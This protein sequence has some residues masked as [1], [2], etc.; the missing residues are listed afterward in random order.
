MSATRCTICRRNYPLQGAICHPCKSGESYNQDQDQGLKG[1]DETGVFPSEMQFPGP[2][3]NA[4]APT[5]APALVVNDGGDDGPDMYRLEEAHRLGQLDPVPVALGAMPPFAGRV[6]RRV[7]EHMQLRMGLRRAD[8]EDRP[9]PY[10]TSQPV[11]AGLAKDKAT[12]S[13]A[14]R[15]LV[16]AGVI[17][18]VGSFPP[19]KPGSDGTKLYA[20]PGGLLA[21]DEPVTLGE[22]EFVDRLRIAFDAEEID[23][24]PV[25][26]IVWDFRRAAS[27][28]S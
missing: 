24:P 26:A 11:R 12:A 1:D 7:A 2:G 21:P 20:P 8:G 17:D 3:C 4:D 19:L 18:H 28:N 5:R 22:D 9:L 15:A 13:N 6:M 14:I 16:R 10:A 23:E 25:P 27:C